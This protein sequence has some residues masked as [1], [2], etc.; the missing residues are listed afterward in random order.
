MYQ[1]GLFLV[2]KKK[3]E[4]NNKVHQYCLI[5]LTS[6]QEKIKVNLRK[7]CLARPQN[8]TKENSS[9]FVSAI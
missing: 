9:L 8:S 1:E 2:G 3:K 5:T 6:V 7:G 4:A